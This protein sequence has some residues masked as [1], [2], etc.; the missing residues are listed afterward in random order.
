[1][2]SKR[3]KEAGKKNGQGGG[4]EYCSF[5]NS[6]GDKTMK[7]ELPAQDA[8]R[9]AARI[10]GASDNAE[11]TARFITEKLGVQKEMPK[12]FFRTILSFVKSYMAKAPDM[13]PEAWLEAEYSKPEYAELWEGRD[14]KESAKGICDGIAGY[15]AAKR[16]L[17]FH[18]EAG[19]T[20]A[21]WLATQ[22]EAGAEANGVDPKVYAA[23]VMKG[24][25]TAAA[26]NAELLPEE[27]NAKGGAQ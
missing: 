3:Q 4:Y 26:E 21:S 12:G 7:N 25:E 6:E 9:L 24:L 8:E 2:P 5:I 22:V 23:E 1:M 20:Q 13:T 10:E 16:D 18:L 11:E 17:D 27:A 19:G 14:L 15:E